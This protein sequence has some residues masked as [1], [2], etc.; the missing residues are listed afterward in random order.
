M[1]HEILH[2]GVIMSEYRQTR[3]AGVSCRTTKDGEEVFYIK[4]KR[5]GKSIREKVGSKSEGVTA[6]HAFKLKSKI[7]SEQRLGESAPMVQKQNQLIY[8]LL[9]DKASTDYLNSIENLPDGKTTAGRYNN[10][11]KEYF[12]DI[13]LIDITENHIIKFKNIKQN[14]VSKKTNK[15]YS[16]KTINDLVNL[17]NTIFLYNIAKYDAP[18]ISP[19]K[20]KQK[21]QT[22]AGIVRLS[23]NNE[24]QRYLT[25][26]EVKLVYQAIENRKS[27]NKIRG[28]LTKEVELFTALALCTGA[29]MTAVLSIKKQDINLDNRTVVMNDFKNDGIYTS[30]LS[31]RA[32]Q[33]LKPLMNQCEH[34]HYI[35]GLGSKPKHKNNIARVLQDILNKL[36]N[37]GLET[38]DSQNRVVIHTFRHTFGSLLAINGTPIYTIKKLM[39]H[40]D[41]NMTMRYAKLAPDSGKDFVLQLKI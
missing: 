16:H 25:E 24:R 9:F 37:E 13:K 12:G 28:T 7:V 19:A 14:E 23:E 26:D 22:G 18:L 40:S 31:D 36:F 8:K 4:F 15:P 27:S 3:Y 32:I 34:P 11:L 38:N 21:R 10:H 20:S 6:L 17:I 5:N 41:I 29:R 39:N 33:L 30:F 35:I 1:V 2:K